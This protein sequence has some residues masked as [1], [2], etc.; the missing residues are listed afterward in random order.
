MKKHTFYIKY[1]NI[2]NNQLEL[3]YFQGTKKELENH[4]R[5]RIIGINIETGIT[6]YFD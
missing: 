6:H 5:N 2:Y 3:R 4:I 1:N